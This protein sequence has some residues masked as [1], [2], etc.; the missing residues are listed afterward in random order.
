MKPAFHTANSFDT[1]RFHR[2]ADARALSKDCGI[3]C[4]QRDNGIHHD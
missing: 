1:S 2:D 4:V 3:P